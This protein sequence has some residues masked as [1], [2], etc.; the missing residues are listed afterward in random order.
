MVKHVWRANKK[1]R[2]KGKV[3]VFLGFV[4]W[5]G[6]RVTHMGQDVRAEELQ[7]IF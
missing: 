3:D 7:I 6:A 1:E 5:G 2:D 4:F